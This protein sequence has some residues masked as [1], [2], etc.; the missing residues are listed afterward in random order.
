MNTHLNCEESVC[1]G[2]N[3]IGVNM[4]L[5]PLEKPKIAPLLI[6][7]YYNTLQRKHSKG[8]IYLNVYF[9]HRPDV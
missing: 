8:K 7:N 2:E 6:L 4:A 9:K 1:I 5:E 3:T